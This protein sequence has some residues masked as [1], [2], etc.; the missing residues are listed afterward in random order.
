MSSHAVQYLFGAELS[1]KIIM[2]NVQWK[3]KISLWLWGGI[4]V[5][6]MKENLIIR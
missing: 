6:S 5:E 3:I 2:S 1:V 4:H